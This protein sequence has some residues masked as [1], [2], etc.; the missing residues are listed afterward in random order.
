MNCRLI[1]ESL[2][3]RRIEIQKRVKGSQ[4]EKAG[5]RPG[6]LVYGPFRNLK[7]IHLPTFFYYSNDKNDE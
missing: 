4:E 6:E 7:H 2:G 1:I 3:C 5:R